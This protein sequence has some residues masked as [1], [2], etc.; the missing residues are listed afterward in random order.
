MRPH[1]YASVCALL[2]KYIAI[3]ATYFV[4]VFACYLNLPRL[5][6]ILDSREHTEINTDKPAWIRGR[7]FNA[8][9]VLVIITMIHDNIKIGD[10]SM[11][12]SRRELK[13]HSRYS[14]VLIHSS[15]TIPQSLHRQMNSLQL[16]G[17]GHSRSQSGVHKIAS[18]AYLFRNYWRD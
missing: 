8:N 7:S 13:C 10:T 1:D 5:A 3:H 16:S 17:F 18:Q 12:W 9:L 6:G 11:G 14:N 2:C 15:R 4:G